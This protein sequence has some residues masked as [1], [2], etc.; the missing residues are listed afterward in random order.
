MTTKIVM[1]A[2]NFSGYGQVQAIKSTLETLAKDAGHR[3]V[4][5]NDPERGS[6]AKIK[7][8]SRTLVTDK[9]SPKQLND[10]ISA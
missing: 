1:F 5:V 4:F 10:F 8:D 7:M 9:F 6:F 3:F 2:S